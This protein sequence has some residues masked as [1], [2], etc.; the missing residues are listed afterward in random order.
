MKRGGGMKVTLVVLLL[1]SV[2]AVILY[3]SKRAECTLCNSVGKKCS[4]S[5]DC[6]LSCTCLKYDA[7]DGVCYPSD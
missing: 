5:L 1:V 6:G 3:P 2:S 7:F 4:F